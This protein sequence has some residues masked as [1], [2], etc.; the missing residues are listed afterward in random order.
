MT[1]SRKVELANNLSEIEERISNAA[2]DSNRDRSSITLIVVTKTFPVD[3]AEILY[4][5]GIRDFGE[6]RDHEG[7]LKAPVLP[8]DARWHFQGQIQ[9]RKIASISKW[10]SV[11]HSLDSQDHARKFSS[12]QTADET[13]VREFFLQINLDPLPGH[14]GGIPVSDIPTFLAES[15]LTISGLMVV[16]PLDVNPKEAF[17]QVKGLS[18]EFGL[19]NI[20]MGMSGDFEEAIYAG[21]THIRVGSSILGS[22]PRLT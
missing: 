14:R 4:D 11:V 16:P 15:P 12:L 19:P 18:V 5:L 6:N 21:A 9:G 3:D 22:R 17:F 13:H 8:D 1:T 2:R 20:S 10:A 7:S